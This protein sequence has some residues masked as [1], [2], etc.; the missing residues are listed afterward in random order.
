MSY[1]KQLFIAGAVIWV[2][3]F[4]LCTWDGIARSQEINDSPLYQQCVD[5]CVSAY[6]SLD[7]YY[8]CQQSCLEYPYVIV[9]IPNHGKYHGG[10]D[11]GRNHPSNRGYRP[12]FRGHNNHPDHR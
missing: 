5:E 2:V 8:L 10:R 3:I 1:T 11:I 4:L 12:D 6:R 9:E 7:F